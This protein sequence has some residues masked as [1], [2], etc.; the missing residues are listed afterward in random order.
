MPKDAAPFLDGDVAMQKYNP[1]L[2]LHLCRFSYRHRVVATGVYGIVRHPMYLAA[3][4][5]F[6]RGT[7]PDRFRGGTVDGA[8]PAVRIV[9]EEK[10]LAAHLAGY[11]DYRRRVRY[12]LVPFVQE[13]M[14]KN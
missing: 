6:V 5:M 1:F 9:S 12:R 8:A 10:V 2:I 11:D 4:L 14:T 13:C 3:V 7:A